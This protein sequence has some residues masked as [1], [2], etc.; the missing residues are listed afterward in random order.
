MADTEVSPPDTESA[1][2]WGGGL[3]S[4]PTAGMVIIIKTAGIGLGRL[5]RYTSK[6]YNARHEV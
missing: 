1:V 3:G 4:V 6:V 2:F 5:T